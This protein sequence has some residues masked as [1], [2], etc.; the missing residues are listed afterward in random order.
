MKKKSSVLKIAASVLSLCFYLFMATGSDESSSDSQRNEE[1]EEEE[2][3]EPV[4]SKP[5]EREPVFSNDELEEEQ[6]HCLNERH[7]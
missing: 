3:E 5:I 4:P 6:G 2:Y 1:H 7:L